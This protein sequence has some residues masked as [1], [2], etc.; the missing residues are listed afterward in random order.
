MVWQWQK[1]FSH[2]QLGATDG[3]VATCTGLRPSELGCSLNLVCHVI[4][5]TRVCAQ[6][7]ERAPW[8]SMED[9]VF[10]DDDSEV[11][12]ATAAAAAYVS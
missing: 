3:K 12:T 2:V 10:S 1:V 8:I 7:T 11:T 9:T 5:W 6:D 4:M